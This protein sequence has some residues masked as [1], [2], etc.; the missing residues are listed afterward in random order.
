ME[1]SAV[2]RCNA[3]LG[4]VPVREAELLMK[5][6]LALLSLLIMGC[7]PAQ[8]GGARVDP[9]LAALVPADTI[10][11]AGIRMSELRSTPLYTKMIAEKRL[12]ELDDFA[13]RTNFDPRKDV[14]ELLV[15]SNGTD[16]VVLARGNFKIQAPAGTRKSVYKGA[17]LY[18]QGDGAYA[19]LDATTAV[20]GVESAVRK[21][22]DQKQS[23]QRGA[24]GLIDRAR[25]LSGPGQIWVVANGWGALP[26]RLSRDGGNLSNLSRFFRGVEKA[27][28]TVDLRSGLVAKA[29]GE[30]RTEQDAKTLG[31]AARGVVG[32]GRLTVPE[33]KPE[34]LK[35]FDGIKVDQKDRFIDVDVNV[36]A[37][38]LDGLLQMT[39]SARGLTGRSRN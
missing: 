36:P 16:N 3:E 35:L 17:T 26:D 9:A 32:L 29:Q 5:A 33:N 19:I 37:D 34:M 28:A 27:T 11:L 2:R 12:S 7:S 30:C 18:G 24:A 25:G 38:L 10:V 8:M 20:A 6:S 15:A 14:N 13:K 22:I 23:G 39:G 31:D 4:I 1:L 21:A